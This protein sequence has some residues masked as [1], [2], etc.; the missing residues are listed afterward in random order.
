MKKPPPGSVA[1]VRETA[2]PHL[3]GLLLPDGI[4]TFPPTRWLPRFHR[5]SPSTALDAYCYVAPVYP[6]RGRLRNGARTLSHLRVRAWRNLRHSGIECEMW[7]TRR[8]IR[9]ATT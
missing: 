1:E 4:G 8:P 2:C 7:R 5:A 3:P 9:C 6:G